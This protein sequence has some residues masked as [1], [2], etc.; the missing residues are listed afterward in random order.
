MGA[1]GVGITQDDTVSDVVGFLTD[2]LKAG[3]SLQT[4]TERTKTHFVQL[5][6][7]ENEAPLFWLALAH[8]QWKYGVVE[9]PILDHVRSDITNDRGLERW[10]EDTK[11]LAKRKAALAKFISQIEVS[12]SK[13]SKPPKLIVRRAP[14]K[15]GDCLSIVLSDGRYT[16][17]LV[18]NVDNSNQ[19]YGKNLIASL[20]YLSSIPPSLEVFKRKDWLI[21]SHGNWNNRKDICWYLPVRFKKESERIKVVGNISLERSLPKEDGMYSNWSHLGQQILLVYAHKAHQ[22]A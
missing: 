10:K 20:D 22:N 6:R 1:W 19:E 15:H 7:D 14:F 12:N 11:S 2:Q 4:A 21:L 17:A 18:L 8:V 9:K 13:P 16:A 3:D 5:E